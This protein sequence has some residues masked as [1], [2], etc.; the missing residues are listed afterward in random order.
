MNEKLRNEIRVG[1]VFALGLIIFLL[2]VIYFIAV[3]PV[4][5]IPLILLGLFSTYI[6]AGLIRKG[7]LT[8]DG[9]GSIGVEGAQP[10]IEHP[11]LELAVEP[12]PQIWAPP[13][14]ISRFRTRSGLNPGIESELVAAI[15]ARGGFAAESAGKVYRFTTLSSGDTIVYR[16]VNITDPLP[17]VDDAS[18]EAGVLVVDLIPENSLELMDR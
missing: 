9:I 5:G 16:D 2:G 15:S 1:I 17:A 4:L 18:R 14:T 10:L 12:V 7:T 13:D 11:P 3:S 6:A 8:L